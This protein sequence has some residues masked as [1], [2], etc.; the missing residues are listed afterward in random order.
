MAELEKARA[1]KARLRSDLA[2]QPGVCGVGITHGRDGYGV[3]VNL[4]R[5][6]DR[7]GVP[8]QVDGVP[9]DVRV[10]GSIRAGG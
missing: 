10:S 5:E 6:S 1:A 4:R 8:G 7:D 3:R 9:V 2:G